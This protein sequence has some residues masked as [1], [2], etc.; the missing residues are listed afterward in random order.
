MAYTRVTRTKNGRGALLYAIGTNGKGHNGK[1]QRNACIG[2][3]N[4]LPGVDFADQMQPYWDR[5]SEQ[6]KTQVLRIVQ[7]FSKK[8][9]DPDSP[10]DIDK[11][12]QLGQEYARLYYEGRQAVVCTQIDGK[13]GCVH[14][15]IIVNDV[16]MDTLMGCDKEQYH[17]STLK[18]WTDEI[19]SKYT[20]LDTGEKAKDKV[21]QT[22]RAKREKGEYVWKDDLKDRIKAAMT[23][24]TSEQDYFDRLAA[25]GVAAAQ[26]SSKKYGDYFTYE[27]LEIPDGVKVNNPKARS[28]NL[29]EIY[30][31][32]SL[33]IVL[34][35]RQQTGTDTRQEPAGDARQKRSKAYTD[36]LQ[37]RDKDSPGIDPVAF[38]AWCE[39]LGDDGKFVHEQADGSWVTDMEKYSNLMQR[40]KLHKDAPEESQPDAPKS[41]ETPPEP[42]QAPV[43]LQVQPAGDDEENVEERRLRIQRRDAQRRQRMQEDARQAQAAAKSGRLIPD[44]GMILRNAA[45][46]RQGENEFT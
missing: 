38:S 35:S 22:E 39:T 29:G 2:C 10:A 17:H 13:G 46:Q 33:R 6:H 44:A 42:P 23:E 18:R 28:Y 12:N 30:G 26:K 27:L 19:T 45:R 3:V 36:A 4:L 11:A 16:H 15:H 5:A 40:Y 20:T 31:V 34:M 24:A 21:S 7:S 8:E 14:N 37:R 43:I 41:Q 25:H 9:F 32:G 1:D